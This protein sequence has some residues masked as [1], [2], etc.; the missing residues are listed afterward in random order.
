MSPLVQTLLVGVLLLAAVGYLVRWG[1]RA[2][3]SARTVE[4]PGCGSGCGCG[5]GH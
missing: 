5:D 4:G 2:V 3:R 1:W